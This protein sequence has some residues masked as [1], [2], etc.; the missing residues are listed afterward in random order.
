MLVPVA[1][2]KP[3]LLTWYYPDFPPA[4][5]VDGAVYNQD[6]TAND[7]QH[8]A[9][10]GSTVTLVRH[11]PGYVTP[12]AICLLADLPPGGPPPLVF[13]PV[14]GFVSALY[15]V[16][17]QVP[18]VPVGAQKAYVGLQFALS[19]SSSIPPVSNSVAVYVK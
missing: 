2:S 13:S 19:P 7:A 10:A 12:A 4:N 11:R 8:P 5:Y 18:N 17:L 9:P 14:P 16:K 1:A 6:G 3:G 15:Q